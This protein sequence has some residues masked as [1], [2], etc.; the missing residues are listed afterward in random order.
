M[1]L[2]QSSV[3]T[4]QKRLNVKRLL[5]FILVAALF[6]SICFTIT[7]F[8]SPPEGEE[9]N[10]IGYTN[11][12]NGSYLRSQPTTSS[13]RLALLPRSSRVEVFVK[14]TGGEVNGVNTWYYVRAVSLNLEGYVHSPLVT[15][16][17]APIDTPPPVSN[18]NFEAHL[19]EQGFPASYKPAL[20]S[21]HSAHP[22]WIFTAQHIKDVDSPKTNR[23]PLTFQKA[24]DEEAKPGIN[25]VGSTSRLSHRSYEPADYYYKTNKWKV[26]DAGGW[27]GASREIIA[28]SIDPRNFLNEQ[29]MF[30]F[31]VLSYNEQAH[32]IDAVEAALVGTFMD[33]KQVTFIDHRD[34]QEKT[35][36]Y[37]E[38][39]MEAAKITNV[40]P[41][42]LVQRCLMEVSR[43]GSGSVSGTVAGYE[44]YYNFYNIGA[45]A[46]TNPVLNALKYARYGR[47]AS[48]PTQT[49]RNNYLLP[50]DSQ[51]RAIVGGA[52]W[53]G[54]GYVNAGQD[55]QYSQKFNLDGD[56]YGTYWHQYM[57]NVYAP[58]YEAARVYEM[59]NQENLLNMPFIFKI[60]VL[61]D[62]P[63]TPSP[64]PTSNKS[65]NNWLKS[66]EVSAGTLTPAFNP[67]VYSY[68]V[69]V[70]GSVNEI[71]LT[72]EPYLSSCSINHVG[73]HTLDVGENTIV[74]EAVSE[75]GTKRLYTVVVNKTGEI[76]PDTEPTETTETTESTTSTTTSTAPTT[77]TTTTTPSTAPTT[78]TTTTPST[79]PTTSTTTPSTP[80]TTPT[81]TTTPSTT[82][83]QNVMDPSVNDDY[84]IR[85]NFLFNAYPD[86][87]RNQAGRIRAALD[88]P[89]GMTVKIKDA[90]GKVASDDTLLG[91]GATIEWLVGSSS[92]PIATLTL[93]IYGDASGN[94]K[95]NSNDMS[96]IIDYIYAGREVTPAQLLAMDASRNGVVN[97]NDLS[98]IIDY[99]YKG[100]VIS[101]K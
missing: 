3:D 25:V 43:Q 82:P 65:L 83:E 53:I 13:S 75:R 22:E 12:S 45:T 39:F 67:E 76:P 36:T 55:T 35:M 79:T 14:V 30:Q 5:T 2:R 80:P 74:L 40:S 4:A 27:I 26:Y 93:V 62:M 69:T 8:A 68:A 81:T 84:V 57:G 51:W 100:R 72:A 63:A 85:D 88:I 11:S 61:A 56:T 6:A 47:Y 77:P 24:L 70:E 54:S 38:I 99:I 1:Y 44:G 31:E 17:N 19:T 7:P 91:T 97:S 42:F 101:Q 59:Y 18:P 66:I 89:D 52:F 21:L 92:T 96:Y 32:H 16:T 58:Y 87:G 95:I 29:Q 48:G 33:G 94:G 90:T 98:A 28:Y 78:P 15:L 60:P 41:F 46:G 23:K 20:R 73:N 34:Q 37:A 71:T 64:Y 9:I 50:W 86:E 49:E 10:R